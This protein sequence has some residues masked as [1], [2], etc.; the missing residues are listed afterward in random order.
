MGCAI[1]DKRKGN[2]LI[3]VAEQCLH[4]ED[5]YVAKAH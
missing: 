5:K 3:C 4:E 2:K 1:R